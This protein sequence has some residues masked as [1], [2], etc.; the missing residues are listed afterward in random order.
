MGKLPK[1]VQ[2]RIRDTNKANADDLARRIKNNIGLGDPPQA[3][4]VKDTI[5]GVRDRNIRVNAGGKKGVG[6]P[7]KS[8][9]SNGRKYRPP[10]GALIFG[11]EY[12]SSGKTQDRKGRPMGPRF[13]KPH[14]ERGNFI[15]PAVDK[16]TP[17]LLRTWTKTIQA[18]LRKRGF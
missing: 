13:V 6:R 16:Y 5:V 9:K 12:G 1:D 7:Y 8:T 15:G 14:N 4:L 3:E 18:E 11:A 2:N 10:A 17:Q